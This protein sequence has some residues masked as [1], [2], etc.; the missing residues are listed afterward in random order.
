M[1][2]K[3]DLEHFED[4]VEEDDE[5][6]IGKIG[7]PT[8]ENYK[9]YNSQTFGILRTELRQ[10]EFMDAAEALLQDLVVEIAVLLSG[11]RNPQ[12][13]TMQWRLRMMIPL[14]HNLLVYQ[15]LG[16]TERYR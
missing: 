6:D 4:I 8:E 11:E 3:K 7:N 15:F 12:S 5:S 10:N 1:F 13:M 14:H 9:P 2:Q 16:I